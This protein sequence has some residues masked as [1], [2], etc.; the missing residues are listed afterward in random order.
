[1]S[2]SVQKYFL[3]NSY[4]EVPKDKEELSKD[5][6]NIIELFR[7]LSTEDKATVKRIIREENIF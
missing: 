6:V 2:D 1:M 5:V 7:L 3:D 4:L